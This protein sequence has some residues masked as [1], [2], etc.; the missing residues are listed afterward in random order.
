MAA[1]AGSEVETC[2]GAGDA[3]PDAIEA[4]GRRGVTNSC[5]DSVAEIVF[6]AKASEDEQVALYDLCVRSC[7]AGGR[8]GKHRE[9]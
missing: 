1:G 9:H 3:G 2:C 4:G 5:S 6:A 7:L 8:Y